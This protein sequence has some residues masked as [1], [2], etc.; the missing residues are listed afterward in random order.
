MLRG[1]QI[2]NV[3]LLIAL[4]LA[5][6]ATFA[7]PLKAKMF[8]TIA[9]SVSLLLLIYQIF[10]EIRKPAQDSEPENQESPGSSPRFIGAWMIATPLLLWIIGFMGTVLVLPFLYLR[11]QKESWRLSLVIPACCGLFFYLLFGLMLKLPLY[12]GLVS[13]LWGN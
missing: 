1:S 10:S 4:I 9:L 12:P 5:A 8:P 7:Y 13:H 2:F 11:L 6:L 3:S